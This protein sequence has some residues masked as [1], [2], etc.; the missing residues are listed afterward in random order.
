MTE[1]ILLHRILVRLIV[2]HMAII[3][4]LAIRVKRQH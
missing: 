1:A 3:F 4:L 2:F